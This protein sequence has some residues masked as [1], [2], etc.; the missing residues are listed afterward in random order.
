VIG[1]AYAGNRLQQLRLAIAGNTGNADDLA[2]AHLK[3][4]ILDHVDAAAVAHRQVLDREHDVSWRCGPLFDMQKHV[5]ADHE[6]GKLLHRS[7]CGGAGCH[8]LAAPHDGDFIRHRHDLAQLVGDQQDGF[9]FGLELLE[10]T[11]QVIGLRR[12]QHA[13][14]LVEDQDLRTAVQRLEDLDA[15][16][17]ADGQFLDDGIGIDLE[18]I[19]LF[20]LLELASGLGDSRVE[21]LAFLGAEHDVFKHAEV[22]DQHEMLVNHA[23]AHRNGG[24]RVLDHGFPAVNEDVAIVGLIEAVEDRHQC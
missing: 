21:H 7:L 18:L 22:L 8:H 16:L 12:G 20:E 13:G 4:D 5:T 24:V 2:G 23:D 10:D 6:L 11:E 9:A 3:R 1:T 17:Y 19:F 15:L 14:G